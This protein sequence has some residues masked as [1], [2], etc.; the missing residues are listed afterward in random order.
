[1]LTMTLSCLLYQLLIYLLFHCNLGDITKLYLSPTYQSNFDRMRATFS[2]FIHRV[3]P[4]IKSAIM[5]TSQATSPLQAV[6]SPLEELKTY[7]M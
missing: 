1:M 5:S 4:I 3:V 7:Q 6:L 2:K